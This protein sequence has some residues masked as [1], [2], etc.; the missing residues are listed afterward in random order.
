MRL[1]LCCPFAREAIQ[2]RT[3]TAPAMLRLSVEGRRARRYCAA[4]GIGVFR[5]LSEIL[6]VKT[7][8]EAGY[9]VEELPGR[10]M[11]VAR[12]RECGVHA[13]EQGIRLSFHPDPFVVLNS[14]NPRTLAR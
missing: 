12:F 5:I 13:R 4:H 9:G 3:T 1:G 10:A 8:P 14:P 7:H 11:W 2:L 6:S